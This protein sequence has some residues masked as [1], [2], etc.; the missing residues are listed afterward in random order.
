MYHLR[1]T[2]YNLGLSFSLCIDY[3]H[4][5]C[6]ENNILCL[7]LDKSPEVQLHKLQLYIIYTASL[8]CYN[9]KSIV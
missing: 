2:G 8:M 7:V 5:S 9:Y 1:A 3:L 4:L 6:C